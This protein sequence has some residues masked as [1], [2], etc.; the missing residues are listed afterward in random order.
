MTRMAQLLDNNLITHQ[1]DISIFKTSPKQI[2]SFDN[3]IAYGQSN[4]M[5]NRRF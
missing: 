3:S 4:S 2:Q 5:T 1:L